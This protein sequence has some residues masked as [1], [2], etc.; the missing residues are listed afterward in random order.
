MAET[1]ASTRGEA[2]YGPVCHVDGVKRSAEVEPTGPF[3]TWGRPRLASFWT[4]RGRGSYTPFEMRT[5]PSLTRRSLLL[6]AALVVPLGCSE[7][8]PVAPSG[9]ILRVSAYPTRISTRGLSTVTVNAY[10]ST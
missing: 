3:L 2:G 7:G 6:L 5:L 9:T 4:L 8:T 10:R 1:F